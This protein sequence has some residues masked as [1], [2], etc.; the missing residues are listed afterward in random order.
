VAQRIE[1]FGLEFA[2]AAA[3]DVELPAYV[4]TTRFRWGVPVEEGSAG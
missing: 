4:G 1:F 2:T 3:D